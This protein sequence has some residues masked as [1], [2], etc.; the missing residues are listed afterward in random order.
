MPSAPPIAQ[1]WL[2]AILILGAGLRFFPIWFG[3]TYPYSRPDETE[4]VGH[5]LAMLGGDL[6]P[7]FFHWP[8]LTFYLFAA[9]FAVL[10][11]IRK[12]LLDDPA[13][14]RDVAVLTGRLIV[15]AAGTLTIVPAYRLAMRVCDWRAGLAAAFFL[16]VAVL[17]VRDSH[18][19]MTDVLMTLFVTL[20]LARLAS[21]FDAASDEG[22]GRAPVVGGFAVAGLLAGLATSTKYNAAAVAVSMAVAQALLLARS[23]KGLWS[24]RAWMPLIAFTAA[25]AAGFLL[26]TPYSILDA[27]KFME[28]LRYDLTHL[29]EPHGI[30]VGSGWYAHLTRS[31]PYGCGFLIFAAAVAGMGVA[32]RRAPR[33]GLVLVAFVLAFLGVLGSGR[34][35][36]FRYVMPLVPMACVFAAFTAASLGDVA[37]RWRRAGAAA[38][39]LPTLAVVLVIGAPSLISSAWMD[40]LLARTD[41]RIIAGQWLRGQLKPDNSVYDAG[42]T[43][44]RLDLHSADYHAWVYDPG[45]GSFGD[46]EGRTPHW[47]VISESPLR[48]YAQA[49]PSLQRLAAE[50][51]S[52]VLVVPGTRSL[53]TAA[54]YDRQDA[55]FLPFSRFREVERPGP[56]ITIYRRNE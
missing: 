9:V 37:A 13:L 44:V 11:G 32:L 8:S 50:R 23:R 47:L 56:T 30:D 28:D 36:F 31:L 27:A 2:T 24:P 40:L 42:G 4:A 46:P 5:A 51:Y 39:G 29:S 6:N 21:A 26:G 38:T 45:T 12:I 25:A 41:S 14:T 15:A 17:H 52:P 19:A 16:A 33:H 49:E 48:L 7:H 53:D 20:A 10:S 18:F 34:T 54:V 35:V 43:Y 22:S 55:F 3:L 1:R